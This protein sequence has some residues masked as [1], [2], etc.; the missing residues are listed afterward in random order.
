MSP[1]G[2]IPTTLAANSFPVINA[3]RR[4]MLKRLYNGRD[5]LFFRG[6]GEYMWRL[7]DA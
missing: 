7:L 1:C 4:A 3:Q 5:D 6:V 2:A